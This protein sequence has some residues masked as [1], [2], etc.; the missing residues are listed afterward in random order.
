MED[1]NYAKSAQALSQRFVFLLDTLSALR[2]LSGARLD[3]ESESALLQSALESL[4]QYQDLENCSIFLR[5]G[6]ELTCAA[7]G[8]AIGQR[9]KGNRRADQAG[10]DPPRMHFTV[11]EGVMGIA[12]VTGEVQDVR[13]CQLDPRFVPFDSPRQSMAV[14]SLMSVPIKADGEVLGVLNVS[15]PEPN[16]FQNWQRQSLSLFSSVLGQMLRKERLLATLENAVVQRTEDLEM[17]L[18]E[19]RA[20]QRQFEKLS[21]VDDLTGLN[22]RR[23][24]FAEAERALNRSLRASCAFTVLLVDI[25]HFKN[26]NDSCGHMVG[27]RVLVKFAEVLRKNVRSGDILARTGGEEFVIAMPDGNLDGG[28]ILAT[29]LREQVPD[30]PLPEEIGGTPL[31]ASVGIAALETDCDRRPEPRELL[32][33]LYNNADKAMYACKRHGRDQ[34]IVYDDTLSD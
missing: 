16:F 20:M 23:F 11:G 29:R 4:V 17:A 31:T 15:H 32:E 18:E 12:A 27:D 25:D 26:I 2:E 7:G 1:P 10:G 8:G 9:L 22:N 3:M 13:D 21:V 33:L 6:S 5:Q 14:R 28:E 19:T 30:I 34:Q 24:F